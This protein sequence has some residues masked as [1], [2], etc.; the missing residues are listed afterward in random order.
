[1]SLA[2][3]GVLGWLDYET[4]PD[5]GFSLFYLVPIAAGAWFVGRGAGI[6]L[7]VAAAIAWLGADLG[8]REQGMGAV[9]HWNAFTRLVIY[10]AIAVLM[11][12]V[13][14][15]RDRL[16]S[17]N[18]QLSLALGSEK[19]LARTDRLT[20]IGNSRK[21]LEHL[22]LDLTAKRSP[23][24]VAF[25]DIDNFKRVNDLHGHDAGD[26]L[27]RR[28]AAD[29]TEVVRA[30]DVTARMGGDEF[31]V[32]FRGV[33]PARAASLGRRIVDRVRAAGE[34]YPEAEIGASVGIAW[35]ASAPAD[36]REVMRAADAA[37]Y[38][39]KAA[40]KGE[41]RITFGPEGSEMPGA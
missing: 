16:A 4:G 27:L 37:M 34:E 13:R 25:L 15:D 6:A 24:C 10:L 32:L 19:R 2:S 14:E 29:L 28:I 20:E 1:M 33:D 9:T 11:A 8:W 21:F 31:A 23:I 3:V 39:A 35:F 26:A 22:A 38:E 7:A 18:A 36:A 12:L 40:G 30:A 5:I 17:L 41:V